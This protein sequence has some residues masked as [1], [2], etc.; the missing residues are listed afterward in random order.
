M[1]YKIQYKHMHHGK[2]KS[3]C[4]AISQN[5]NMHCAQPTIAP[6]LVSLSVARYLLYHNKPNPAA[7]YKIISWT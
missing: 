2:I 3:F 4:V 7:H 1:K 6:L 5:H